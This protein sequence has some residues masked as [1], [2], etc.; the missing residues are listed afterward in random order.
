MISSLMIAKVFKPAQRMMIGTVERWVLVVTTQTSS[1]EY[2]Y[3]DC[4]ISD[5]QQK[6]LE[7]IQANDLIIL[8]GE[9]SISSYVAQDG[10][11]RVKLTLYTKN[12]KLTGQTS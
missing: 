2:A 1:K 12:I 3:M 7:T 6:L 5:H 4:F 8:S 11:A 10:K 9:L